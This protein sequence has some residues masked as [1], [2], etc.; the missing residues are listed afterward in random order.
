[1]KP[2]DFF[3]QRPSQASTDLDFQKWFN[4]A[5]DMNESISSGFTD[6][7]HKIFTQDFY[8]LLGDP[9]TKSALEIG[10][11]GGRLLLP[12]SFF[13]RDVTGIDIHDENSRVKN[14]LRNHG[15]TNVELLR[16]EERSWIEDGS[17]DF[18]YSFITFQ[19]FDEWSVA[20]DYFDLLHQKLSS[21]GVG[22]IYFGSQTDE[23]KFQGLGKH[24]SIAQPSN[25]DDFPMIVHTNEQFVKEQMKSRGLEP[26]GSGITSKRPWTPDQKSRQ[27]YVKF[28]NV[29]P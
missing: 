26:F 1:M 7:V 9:S 16:Y 14:H 28:Q 10:H 13:F 21:K 11:G 8:P 24:L 22:I 27:F 25:F 2:S 18:V 23:M 12:A 3:S 29:N 4:G 17:I 20:A 6:F 19:H 15:R 5:K